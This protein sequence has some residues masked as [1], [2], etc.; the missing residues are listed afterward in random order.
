MIYLDGVQVAIAIERK[1]K[2]VCGVLVP[3]GVQRTW[4]DLCDLRE[5]LFDHIPVG[6]YTDPLTKLRGHMNHDTL[7]LREDTPTFMP[8]PPAFQLNL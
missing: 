7:T 2:D 3:R 8:G 6:A 5:D 4:H 1:A